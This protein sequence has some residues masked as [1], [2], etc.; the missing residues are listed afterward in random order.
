LVA[1]K[2]REQIA[3]K[4]SVSNSEIDGALEVYFE[5]PLRLELSSSDGRSWHATGPDL[6]ETLKALRAEASHSGTLVLCA[7]ARKDVYPSRMSRQMGHARKAYVLRLGQPATQNDLIDIFASAS[8]EQIATVPDQ[9]AFYREWLASLQMRRSET[10]PHPAEIEEAKRTPNGWVYRIAPGLSKTDAVP[11]S[12]I[13]GAWKV[14]ATGRITG[15]FV[16]N[17]RYDANRWPS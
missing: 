9:E 10:I 2:M 13:I 16:K 4:L 8:A 3:I 17:E 7:G 1:I 15:S 11:P 14:D 5:S 12:A 6:F